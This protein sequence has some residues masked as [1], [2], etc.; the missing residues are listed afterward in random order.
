MEKI[1]S[2]LILLAPPLLLALTFHEFSHGYVANQLGDPTARLAGRL[3]M[4]PIKHLDPIGTLAFFFV[5]FGWAKP[6]PVNPSYFRDP[7]KG[8]LWVALAGPLSNLFLAIVSAIVVKILIVVITPVRHSPV[9]TS[10]LLPFLY[11]TV[12]S[13]WINLMLSIFNLLPVPPLDG[14]RILGG[15]L[16]ED[17]YRSYMKIEPY[18]FVIVVL[19]S[20]SGVLSFIISPVLQLANSLLLP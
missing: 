16:P 1:I 19:L 3:T 11:M 15:L 14:G 7:R 5:K 17:M 6:V 18:G 4:N 13:V 20:F 9:A 2:D 8:M 10:I 12:K